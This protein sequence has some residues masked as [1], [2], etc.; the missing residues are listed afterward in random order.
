MLIF[1]HLHLSVHGAPLGEDERKLTFENYGLDPEK[2]FNVS[3][4]VYDLN[5]SANSG[6][7]S[8][9]FSNN[10]FHRD[11]SSLARFNIVFWKISYTSSETLKRFSGSKP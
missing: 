8:A 4:E 2:R 10:E 1:F 9:Y 5:S 7:V 11:S 3:E 6:Y